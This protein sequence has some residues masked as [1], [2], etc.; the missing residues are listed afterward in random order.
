[1]AELSKRQRMSMDEIAEMASEIARDPEAGA[2]RFRAMKFLAQA[3]ASTVLLPDPLDEPEA[4]D[5]LARLLKGYGPEVAR[6][7]Y[8]RA[9]PMHRKQIDGMPSNA[10]IRIDPELKKKAMRIRTL[11]MLY[12]VFPEIKRPG[13][14]PGYPSGGGIL[15]QQ[16]Y[17]QRKALKMYIDADKQAYEQC[18]E[19]TGEATGEATEGTQEGVSGETPNQPA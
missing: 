19:A 17:V 18:A 14:P 13:V 9:Y 6:L 11:K 12:K 2:D 10:E 5:R 7:A 3:E 1:M 15:V 4:I 8:R 16:E